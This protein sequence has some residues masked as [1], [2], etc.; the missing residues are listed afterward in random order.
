M[1]NAHERRVDAAVVFEAVADAICEV[2]GLDRDVL[3]PQDRVRDLGIDSLLSGE[4]LARTERRLHIDIDYRAVSDDWSTMTVGDLAEQ[5][6]AG[7]P[8]AGP[9]GL[10]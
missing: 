1:T 7:G 2:C 9:R 6:L 4:I 8:E 5:L 10:T 3:D